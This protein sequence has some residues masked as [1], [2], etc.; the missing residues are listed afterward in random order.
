VS[1]HDQVSFR[2]NHK[3]QSHRHHKK[4]TDTQNHI[5]DH[6]ACCIWHGYNGYNNSGAEDNVVNRVGDMGGLT[7]SSL[8]EIDKQDI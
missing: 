2:D 6:V 7:I 3:S 1:G 8:E 5:F 4:D